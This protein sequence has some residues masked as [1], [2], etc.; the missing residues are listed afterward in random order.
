MF[1]TADLRPPESRAQNASESEVS[2]SAVTMI[3]A[4]N[5]GNLP[6]IRDVQW[7][8]LVGFLVLQVLSFSVAITILRVLAANAAYF[9]V[10][11]YQLHRELTVCLIVQVSVRQLTIQLRV[12][13]SR[14]IG[15]CKTFIGFK[16]V[17]KI[18]AKLYKFDFKLQLN[19]F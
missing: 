18:K 11:T 14:E 5:L 16:K 2:V 3:L 10:S 13:I 17:G 9:S 6:F 12:H 15:N 7:A 19:N 4:P 1:K 8:I